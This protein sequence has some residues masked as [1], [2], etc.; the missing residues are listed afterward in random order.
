MSA[1]V[2]EMPESS[3]PARAL[4]L[5]TRFVPPPARG[6]TLRYELNVLAVDVADVVSGI[7]GWLFDR[8]L[9]GWRVEVVAGADGA[10]VQALRILGLAVVEPD[11][12][13]CSADEVV[14]LAVMDS[15]LGSG[16]PGLGAQSSGMVFFGPELDNRLAERV[17]RVHYRPSAAA[18]VFKAQALAVLGQPLGSAE[19]SERMFRYGPTSDLLDADLTPV[20]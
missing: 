5:P 2:S 10:G 3:T 6:R 14:A 12:W 8:A 16:Q 17:R 13:S 9:A 15:R 20:C 7:G 1:Q 18:R 19:A 4:A 11:N